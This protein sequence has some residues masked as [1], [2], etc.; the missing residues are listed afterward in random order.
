MQKHDFSLKNHHMPYDEKRAKSVQ[1]LNFN[2][3]KMKK[4]KTKIVLEKNKTKPNFIFYR[5]F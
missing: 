4:V 1:K 3:I 5:R 2:E